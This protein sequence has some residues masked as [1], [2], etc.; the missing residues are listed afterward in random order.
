MPSWW[1]GATPCELEGLMIVQTTT[2]EID[3]LSGEVRET[4]MSTGLGIS[5]PVP[6]QL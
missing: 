2:I 3:P 6:M 4:Y 1:Q 5:K